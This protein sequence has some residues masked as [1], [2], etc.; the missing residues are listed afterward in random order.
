MT[1]FRN[2][3][4][5]Y[6]DGLE[7]HVGKPSENVW[8]GIQQKLIGPR[9]ELFYKNAFT[10]FKSAPSQIVWRKVA[11]GVMVRSFLY[12]NPFSFN[13]YYMTALSI[14]GTGAYFGINNYNVPIQNNSEVIA[15][16]HTQTINEYFE[17]ALASVPTADFQES[18]YN[19][20]QDLL[21][22][23]NIYDQ[24]ENIEPYI[25]KSTTEQEIVDQPKEKLIVTE[26]E[27]FKEKSII[28]EIIGFEK[29]N[30]AILKSLSYSPDIYEILD[31]YFKNYNNKDVIIYDTV[32]VDYKGDDIVIKKNYFEISAFKSFEKPSFHFAAI[33]SEYV[34]EIDDFARNT[35]PQKSWALG[36]SVAYNY[37]NIWF[38]SGLQYNYIEETGLAR[39]RDRMSLEV[40]YFEYE[41]YQTWQTDTLA[42]ILDLD[43][44]LQGNT[45]F[46]P[47][48]D[49]TQILITD[50]VLHTRYDT[51]DYVN[52][53]NYNN[54]Y[55]IIGVP[56]LFGYELSAGKF[57]F[58]PKAGLIAGVLIKR[59]GTL[60]NIENATVQDA[61]ELIL[62]PFIFD[63]Y[64]SLNIKLKVSNSFALYVEPNIR[65]SI[66]SIYPIA[67]MS[68]K[69]YRP[70]LNAGLAIRF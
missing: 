55:R 8:K 69:I 22:E 30:P 31:K 16:R 54:N 2:I 47:F 18:S 34:S 23:E 52:I 21:I 36:L 41:S 45:V 24:T 56:L 6:R 38:E 19:L 29:I 5:L 33:N 42:W 63:Y 64:A 62:K 58:T 28:N 14:I 13:I 15:E 35:I 50:S 25:K 1:E 32:G 67:L 53:I 10:S 61:G 9:M 11:A 66:K 46:I 49:S 12:F 57:S 39:V 20:I 37:R 43:E 26:I 3:E 60:Y 4:D 70:G 7:A 59:D 65:G 68:Q 27:E 51:I 40:T 48:L 44:Y 17:E